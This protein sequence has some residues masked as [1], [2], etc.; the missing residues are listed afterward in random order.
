MLS[1]VPRLNSPRNVAVASLLL[2]AVLALLAVGCA[3][4]SQKV[5]DA[6]E[7]FYAGQVQQAAEQLQQL[8]LEV[9]EGDRDVVALN[10]A[11]AQMFSGNPGQAEQTLREV[12]DRLDYL[13]QEDVGETALSYIT[14]D[15]RVSYAGEDYEKILVRFMLA[16]TNLMGDGSDAEAYSLQVNAKQEQIIGA[17]KQL[18]D[19][20]PKESYRRVAAG[21]YLHGILRE[22]THGNYDD[23]ERSFTRVAS[24][25]PDFGAAGRDLQRAREGHHS[26]RGNGV[27]YVF[28]FVGRG[29]YKRQASEIPTSQ[30][31]LIADRILSAVG[32]HTLPPT[33]A[34][35]KVPQVVTW[36]DGVDGVLVDVGGSPV[37]VTETITD[38]G[39]L[40]VQQN[41]AV[42]SHIVAR[43]TI[44]KAAIYAA[45][46]QIDSSNG[47]VSLALSAAGVV[48]EATESA[49]TRCWSL[50]PDTIQ[51]LRL[52]LPAGQYPLALRAAMGQTALRPSGQTSVNIIDG[53]NT[54]V[55]AC[56]PAEQPVGQILVS[57]G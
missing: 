29:P 54:Y 48:W 53:R 11:M 55:L 3:T 40:A 10:L 33:I 21:A 57:G 25:Q 18:A 51:V 50:L 23:A 1:D 14:D 43:G 7:L 9:A 12:R 16:M 28:A 36:E 30:A 5:R 26:A 42:Y 24:W 15:T 27:L 13:E 52:E 4:K 17:G 38:V 56:C 44:K 46:D 32:D 41:E 35:I 31:L 20:N 39:Q 2:P 19:D 49:D 34:A 45:K 8:Q 22:A 6:Q 47:W 37:G